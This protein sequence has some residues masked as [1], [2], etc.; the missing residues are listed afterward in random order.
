[1]L[2][3]EVIE[4]IKAARNVATL[5]EW[6]E[7]PECGKWTCFRTSKIAVEALKQAA[8]S[9]ENPRLEMKD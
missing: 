6:K 7:C 5:S 2:S 3:N 9:A 4:L 1:M 8:E